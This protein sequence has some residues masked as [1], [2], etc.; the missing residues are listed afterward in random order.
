MVLFIAG[1]IGI[2]SG[3]ILALTEKSE[4]DKDLS[5]AMLILACTTLLAYILYL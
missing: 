4:E 3:L 2:V 1:L 5:K